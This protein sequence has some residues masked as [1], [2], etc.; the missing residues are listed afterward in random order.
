[1]LTCIPSR[2]SSR[3]DPL[4]YVQGLKVKPLTLHLTLMSTGESGSRARRAGGAAVVR[5]Y[6][7]AMLERLVRKV[8]IDDVLVKVP[9]QELNQRLI[10]QSAF[11][12]LVSN[13]LLS[14]LKKSFFSAKFML[15]GL[16]AWSDRVLGLQADGQ[17]AG[18]RQLQRKRP[19]DEEW[20]TIS[21]GGEGSHRADT[22][23]DAGQVAAI[24]GSRVIGMGGKAITWGAGTLANV[25]GF[26]GGIVK[27]GL[28]AA[29]QAAKKGVA[30]ADKGV[31]A[32]E[33]VLKGD[34]TNVGGRPAVRGP[35]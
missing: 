9:E 26:A 7:G 2:R 28:G 15:K 25:P 30:V 3:V 13:I 4:M 12:A 21:S 5:Q 16:D 24:S 29:K 14:S 18:N 33:N 1:M 17:V 22:G 23:G 6:A 20:V 32:A 10:T 35:R 19:V 27:S 31:R 34:V 11:Y 8:R